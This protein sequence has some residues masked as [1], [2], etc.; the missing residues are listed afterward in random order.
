MHGRGRGARAPLAIERRGVRQC[1]G[2]RA[3]VA[4][5]HPSARGPQVVHAVRQARYVA[6]PGKGF[7]SWRSGVVLRLGASLSASSAA[8]AAS[9]TILRRRG[10]TV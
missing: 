2:R 8:P 10:A 3:A 9:R 7:L 1:G 5:A 6:C 4:V